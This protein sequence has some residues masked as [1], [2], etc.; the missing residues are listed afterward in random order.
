MK[1]IDDL[2]HDVQDVSENVLGN[3]DTEERLRVFARKA[4]EG[5]NEFLEQLDNTAPEYEY[6]SPDLKYLNGV[7]KLGTLSLQARYTLQALYQTIN[8]YE[9]SLEKLTALMLLNES[10]SRLSR[11]G[12]DIDEFGNFDAPDHDDAEYAY[13]AQYPPQTAYLATKYRELWEGVPAK[14]V[15]DEDDRAEGTKMFPKLGANGSL[16][17]AGDLSDEGFDA[18]DTDRLPSEVREKEE[19]MMMAVIKFRTRYHG[20]RI[21][22]EEH[23]NI[24]FDEFLGVTSTGGEDDLDRVGVVEINEQICKNVV[25]IHGDYIEAYPPLL[26]EWAGMLDDVDEDSTPDR[27]EIEANL[28]A[29]AETFAEAIAEATDLP[30]ATPDA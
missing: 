20:W 29:R 1:R 3:L 11:G 6:T 17:Y 23:L 28:D 4:A 21:F 26:E 27:E 16:A 22:A 19:Q 8:K 7:R 12:F 18:F 10:L 9:Q 15:I 13:G 24:T 2:K 5:D 30:G 14:F 25:R